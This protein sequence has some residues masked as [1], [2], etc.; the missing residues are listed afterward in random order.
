MT[1][2]HL[3]EFKSPIPEASS[4]ICSIAIPFINIALQEAA[5]TG[6]SVKQNAME[7][8]K[9]FDKACSTPNDAPG[10]CQQLGD[11]GVYT[12]RGSSHN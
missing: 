6:T 8:L 2:T 5:T 3:T 10:L 11:V 1:S 7:L 4:R 12:T 9:F